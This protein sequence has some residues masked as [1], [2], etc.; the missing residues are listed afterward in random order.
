MPDQNRELML[1]I[2]ATPQLQSILYD[3]DLLPEQTLGK[4]SWPRTVAMVRIYQEMARLEEERLRFY[5]GDGQFEVLATPEEVVKRRVECARRLAE[6]EA[7]SGAVPC[8][9]APAIQSRWMRGTPHDP[10]MEEYNAYTVIGV[11]NTA[12]THPM[13]PP[14]VVY[15]GDNGH[16]WSLPLAK[17]PGKL[18]PEVRSDDDRPGKTRC[19]SIA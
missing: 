1:Y 5:H 2:N 14:Q 12:N 6:L 13:H 19:G 7:N 15:Q 8:T 16:L 4:P 11:T 17:W 18:V 10:S 9:I 3:T